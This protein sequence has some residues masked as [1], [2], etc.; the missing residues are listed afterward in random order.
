[1]EQMIILT[2]EQCGKKF[3]YVKRSNVIK[4]LCLICAQVRNTA[5]KRSFEKNRRVVFK[6]DMGPSPKEVK[7]LLRDIPDREV[8][9][10]VFFKN[11]ERASG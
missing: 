6:E 5:S 4:K 1:M 11:L 10:E 7:R 2:C 8:N 9:M 3:P